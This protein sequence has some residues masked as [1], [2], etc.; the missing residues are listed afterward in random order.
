MSKENPP[1][2]DLGR[3]GEHLERE[4][5]GLVNGP[6]TAEV[7]QGGRSNLTYR[8]TDG[9]SRWVVRR[10]PLGHV[11]ATAHDMAREY[12]V[13]AQQQRLRDGHVGAVQG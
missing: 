7:V 12:R 13:L 4:R 6:L 2:L 5:P 10:P 8:V 9:T 1:G 3:L 11:L